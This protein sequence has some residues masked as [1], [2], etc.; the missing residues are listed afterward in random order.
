MLPA[1]KPKAPAHYV[2]QSVYD[3]K[4][5]LT[6]KQLARAKDTIRRSNEI[7]ANQEAAAQLRIA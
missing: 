2:G 3:G 6:P 7:K 4:R 1:K 5:Q